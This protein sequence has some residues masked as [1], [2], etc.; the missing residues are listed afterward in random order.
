MR[1]FK[2]TKTACKYIGSGL[3]G[4]F[5]LSAFATSIPYTPTAKVDPYGEC[6][7]FIDINEYGQ[8]FESLECP[9]DWKAHRLMPV[10]VQ[11]ADDVSGAI[12]TQ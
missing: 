9:V 4:L 10:G 6:V 7:G 3:F 1:F 2:T 11:H 8:E 5:V 12:N